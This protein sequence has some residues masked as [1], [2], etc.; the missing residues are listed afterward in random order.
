MSA[1]VWGL[2]NLLSARSGRLCLVGQ[3]LLWEVRSN[4]PS[5]PRPL[6]M[7][8]CTSHTSC[9]RAPPTPPNSEGHQAPRYISTCTTLFQ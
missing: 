7:C 5:R 3:V 2:S 1:G 8:K 9:A 6:L 4:A